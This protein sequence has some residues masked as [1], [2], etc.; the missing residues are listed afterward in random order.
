MN[1]VSPPKRPTMP[2]GP[3]VYESLIGPVVFASQQALDEW[4]K[5][6]L[7]RRLL[8]LHPAAKT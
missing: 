6:P 2:S 1:T 5:Q 8:G 3:V 4:K 7:W